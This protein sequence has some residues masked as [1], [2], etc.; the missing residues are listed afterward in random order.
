MYRKLVY[1]FCGVSIAAALAVPGC[2]ENP[3]YGSLR[4]PKAP[5]ARLAHPPVPPVAKPPAPS[6]AGTSK[7]PPEQ[8]GD[9]PPPP[10]KTAEPGRSNVAAASGT[11]MIVC[12]GET[13]QKKKD[14]NG[15]A[16]AD[17][18][19]IEFFTA[20]LWPGVAVFL[21]LLIWSSPTLVSATRQLVERITKV[22]GPGGFAL[23]LTPKAA[24]EI[25]ARIGDSLAELMKKADREYSQAVELGHIWRRLGIVI[26]EALPAALEAHHLQPRRTLRATIYVPDI[27]FKE[28]LYQL[29]RYYTL[30]VDGTTVTGAPGRRFSM[31]F[32]IIGRAW[33]LQESEGVGN[34]SAARAQAAAQERVDAAAAAHQPPPPTTGLDAKT[35][36]LI[37]DWGMFAEETQPGSKGRPAYL[38]VMLK[39]RDIIEGLLFI[40]S[41]EI[42]AFGNDHGDPKTANRVA[43]YLEQHARVTVLADALAEQM[44][45]LRES[46]PFLQVDQSGQFLQVNE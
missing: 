13:D 11:V 46:G 15:A 4:L 23:E 45:K 31:R 42:D 7:P 36:Q 44:K 24:K 26:R 14:P 41:L 21:A 39:S 19:W 12:C 18:S 32:G 27:I 22:S 17:K 10:I 3:P 43:A 40:D 37:K 16:A 33:R 1:I 38:C 5:R 28:Y 20:A 35:K 9:T 30:T 34:A 25:R 8:P 2:A 6:D 29:T